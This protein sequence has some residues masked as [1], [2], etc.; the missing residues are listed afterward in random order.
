MRDAFK[1]L[2]DSAKLDV[3]SETNR[4]RGITR[5]LRPSGSSTSTTVVLGMLGVVH[6]FIQVLST[7]FLDVLLVFSVC[8]LSVF[9]MLSHWFLCVF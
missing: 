3:N 5:K 6:D 7:C 2:S 8:F 1:I 9:Y 4:D